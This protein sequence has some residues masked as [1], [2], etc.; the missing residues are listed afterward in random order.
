MKC[1]SK[2]LNLSKLTPVKHHLRS[3]KTCLNCGAT[4]Q[5]RYCSHCGQE[6]TEP[7]EKTSHLVKHFFEDITHY[8]SKFFI[9]LKYL[10]FYPG[11]LTREYLAGKRSR[12]LNP[13]RM[14]IFISFVFFLVLFF[15]K[16]DKKEDIRAE[17]NLEMRGKIHRHLADSLRQ[18]AVFKE[19]VSEKDSIRS[20]VLTG[21][22]DSLTTGLPPES[23]DESVAANFGSNGIVFVLV[24][25]RYNRLT[26]YDSVQNTLTDS[27]K[28]K[29][30]LRWIIRTNV[31]LKE[32]YGSRREVVVEEN[33]DHSVPKLMFVLLP[34]FALLIKWFHSRKKYYYAQHVIFSIHFHSFLFLLFLFQMLMQMVNSGILSDIIR[35]LCLAALLVYFFAALKKAYAQSA[36]LA[37][38]KGISISLLYIIVLIISL[39]MLAVFIF[40]TA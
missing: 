39:V 1:S 20:E 35:Y 13:V 30:L 14:Y 9:T 3:D 4:V 12:F 23:Q 37:I 15:K 34:L 19:N 6:N 38:L 5:D 8:D 31:K 24:E 32:K 27:L 11:L 16:T 33:F 36:G 26:E 2:I 21:L 28:D 29:G 17:E 22:A 18:A 40:F 10:L 25:N 7:K